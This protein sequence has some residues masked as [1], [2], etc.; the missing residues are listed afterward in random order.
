MLTSTRVP[1]RAHPT[2]PFMLRRALPVTYRV[3]VLGDGG[4]GKTAVTMQF[5]SNQFV[6]S[7]DPVS[8]PSAIP[9]LARSHVPL[10]RA[11]ESAS[12]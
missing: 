3:T 9:S 6:E 4:V 8:P 12:S 11:H 1:F 10:P 2:L 7:Y 5:V